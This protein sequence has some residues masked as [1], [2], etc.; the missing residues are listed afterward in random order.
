VPTPIE[1]D[2]FIF[3]R[4]I[5]DSLYYF[6][7]QIAD[8]NGYQADLFGKTTKLDIS[9]AQF[10]YGKLLEIY[11]EHWQEDGFSSADNREKYRQKGKDILK[12]FYDNLEQLPEVLYL[13][14]EFSFNFQGESF[15]GKIDRI[16]KGDKGWKIID[17]KTGTGKSVLKYDD[18]RQLILYW[19]VIEEQLQQKVESLA[20]Y[21]L[22]TGQEVSF[23]PTEKEVEK[24]RK[25]VSDFIINVSARN[26][27][28]KPLE[29]TCRY[30]DFKN[31]CEFRAS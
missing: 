23:L 8:R 22:E 21:Y 11:Q 4:T 10:S 13:E 16:D 17:Y 25:E 14:K 27:T 31:I 7:K 12:M 24:F 20:Y 5:H 26:F 28:P 30:C 15:K 9:Q 2:N 18:K 29:F 1:R 3:G 6:L 19:L